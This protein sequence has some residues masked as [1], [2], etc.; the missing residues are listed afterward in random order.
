MPR[1]FEPVGAQRAAGRGVV[2]SG[3]PE[4]HFAGSAGPPESRSVHRSPEHDEAEL[5]RAVAASAAAG[6][7]SRALPDSEDGERIQDQGV[8][9]FTLS[10]E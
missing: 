2:S 5:L 10:N 7:E 9:S 4:G 8:C 1:R 6:A 3:H